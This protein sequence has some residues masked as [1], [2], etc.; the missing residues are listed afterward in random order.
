MTLK[1]GLSS[2]LLLGAGI[3]YSKIFLVSD[4]KHKTKVFT[5]HSK[6]S[7]GSGVPRLIKQLSYITNSSAM[8]QM[9]RLNIYTAIPPISS[10]FSSPWHCMQTWQHVL[11]QKS[12]N[13]PPPLVRA[14]VLVLAWTSHQWGQK[15]TE[16]VTGSQ[17]FLRE[18]ERPLETFTKLSGVWAT[19]E[20]NQSSGNRED[21][22]ERLEWW[23]TWVHYLL[24]KRPWSQLHSILV[25]AQRIFSYSM[26]DLIPWESGVLATRPPV[27]S[28]IT[29]ITPVEKISMPNTMPY[30]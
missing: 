21:V 18:D 28:L 10:A 9:T 6:D 22:A 3:S 30:L 16:V 17:G 8:T 11:S 2:L 26:G 27:K 24:Y 12:L 15:E 23:M 1:L 7:R 5:S 29:V 20:Q 25:A 4:S 14:A 13:W 19:L